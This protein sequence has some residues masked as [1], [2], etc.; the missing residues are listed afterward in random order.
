MKKKTYFNDPDGLIPLAISL[1]ERDIILKNVLLD[2]NLH[3]RIHNA[4]P[5]GTHIAPEFTLEEIELLTDQVAAAAN[6]A[7]DKKIE[8]TLDKLYNNLATMGELID[9]IK[10]RWDKL[11]HEKQQKAVI[12][13]L[14]NSVYQLHISLNDIEPVIWRRIQVLGR[15]S[16]YK[17]NRIIQESMGWTNSH[18]NLFKINDVEYEVKYSNIEENPEALDEKEFKLWQVVQAE[19]VSFT[20]LYD[21]GDYWEHSVLVE[22]I[23]PKEPDVKYPICLDGK[24]ACPPEDCGGPPGFREFVEAVCNPYHEDHQAMIRW[25]G[26]KYDP[27]EFNIALVNK[28][29]ARIR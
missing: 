22:K 17:L 5:Q 27:N 25:V 12:K 9:I 3:D 4:I 29:M 10:V 18:L 23:L 8:K 14:P 6:H 11:E 15:V 1:K 16:L 13:T 19:N 2:K 7:K 20:F 21:Y 26:Y 28:R 24:R